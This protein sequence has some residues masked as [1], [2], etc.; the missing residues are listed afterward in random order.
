LF[1]GC[2][3]SIGQN[4][5]ALRRVFLEWPFHAARIQFTEF[6]VQSKMESGRRGGD[7]ALSVPCK[8]GHRTLIS[9]AQVGS[10]HVGKPRAGLNYFIVVA[11]GT[12]Q[13]FAGFP[14]ARL[15]AGM[16]GNV[17]RQAAVCDVL[18]EQ[19]VCPAVNHDPQAALLRQGKVKYIVK[20]KSD[21]LRRE[22]MSRNEMFESEYLVLYV[23]VYTVRMFA[24]TVL[25]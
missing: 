5:F 13:Q 7:Y 16:S 20:E 18:C 2:A 9:L 11:V 23:E 19:R 15:A 14:Q 8:K 17:I 10:I 24:Q 25:K 1:N 21:R 3:S 22:P 12:H 6:C 4:F